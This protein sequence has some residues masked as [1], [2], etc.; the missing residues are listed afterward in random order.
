MLCAMVLAMGLVAS[1]HLRRRSI[2]RRCRADGATP[3]AGSRLAVERGFALAV[4]SSVDFRLIV[5]VDTGNVRKQFTALC[6]AAG[7]GS[8]SGASGIAEKFASLVSWSGGP[9]EEIAQPAG[10]SN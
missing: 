3:C 10:H 8:D 1:G 9:G 4:V 7:I 5:R 6:K 2:P